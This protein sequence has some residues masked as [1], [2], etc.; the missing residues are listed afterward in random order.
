MKILKKAVE[1]G[2]GAAVYIPKQYAGRQITIILPD[3]LEDIKRNI[4]ERLYD[5][6]G[7]IVG[8]YI[9]GSYARGESNLLSDIDVLIITREEQKELKYIFSDMDARVSTLENLKKSIENIPAISIPI[10]KE[11]K[12]VL[13]PVLI[14]ELRKS[15]INYARFNW[16]FEDIEDMLKTIKT[17]INADKEE[18]SISFIYSLFMRARL[19]YMIDSLLKGF[20]FTNVDFRRELIRRGL[21]KN[22]YDEYSEI[23]RKIRDDEKVEGNIDLKE[24]S[25]FINIVSH[26]LTE[27]KNETKKKIGK[28]N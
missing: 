3:T 21:K 28:R 23:Y 1:I 22:K 4:M 9:F 19:C 20:S 17:F 12:T 16:N 27:L 6:M 25:K 13:N 10:I 26:Y 2:N 18:I 8:V 14:E 7:N 5:Y 15:K 11:S 24:I